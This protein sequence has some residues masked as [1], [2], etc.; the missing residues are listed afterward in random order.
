MFRHAFWGNFRA[1]TIPHLFQLI[2]AAHLK[3]GVKLK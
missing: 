1:E 3:S 2:I